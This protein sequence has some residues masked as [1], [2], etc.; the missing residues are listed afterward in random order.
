MPL[1]SA[2][3]PPHSGL[4]QCCVGILVIVA[5]PLRPLCITTTTTTTAAAI[6]HFTAALA[7]SPM[8]ALLL[9]LL[10]AITG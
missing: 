3:H 9:L 10:H 8:A 1:L 5:A 2:L 7:C 4:R 6:I